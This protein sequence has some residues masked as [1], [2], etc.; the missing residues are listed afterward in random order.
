MRRLRL[1][2]LLPLLPLA[3]SAAPNSQMKLAWSDEFNTP[4]IDATKWNVHNLSLIH[5]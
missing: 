4:E 1:L 3:A 2:A 5:I